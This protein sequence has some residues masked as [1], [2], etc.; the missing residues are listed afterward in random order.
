MAETTIPRFM[1]KPLFSLYG[2]L[3]D[4]N[5]DDIVDPLDEFANF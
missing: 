3:Y 1:R 5:Y 2:L 4:V